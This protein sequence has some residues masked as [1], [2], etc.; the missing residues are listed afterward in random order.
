M[1]AWAKIQGAS[2]TASVR[3]KAQQQGAA[4]HYFGGEAGE[5][6]DGPGIRQTQARVGQRKQMGMQQAVPDAAV[7]QAR[8]DRGAC[9]KCGQEGHMP[10]GCKTPIKNL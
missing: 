6:A 9:F 4:L 3:G 1:S 10:A 7:R 5:N 8:Y 2:E